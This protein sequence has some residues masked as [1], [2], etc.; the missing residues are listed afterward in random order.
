M[1]SRRY[2]YTPTGNDRRSRDVPQWRYSHSLWLFITLTG[3][4]YN[5]APRPESGWLAQLTDGRTDGRRGAIAWWWSPD[6]Y[7]CCAS[8]DVV[9]EARLT[10][11]VDV[12][13][14]AAVDVL[15]KVRS[16]FRYIK[17]TEKNL[18]QTSPGVFKGWRYTHGWWSEQWLT[19]TLIL[20]LTRTRRSR[21]RTNLTYMWWR[22]ERWMF[23]MLNMLSLDK[24][25]KAFRM[26]QLPDSSFAFWKASRL[27]WGLVFDPHTHRNF[28]GNSRTHGL[29]Q[30]QFGDFLTYTCSR[31][32]GWSNKK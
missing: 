9:W 23:I 2:I 24:N 15:A 3:V 32:T 14:Y 13:V 28:R 16:W 17:I 5:G 6:V 10:I 12:A 29:L 27:L 20:M 18:L 31:F 21:T 19:Q 7:I 26:Q 11:S 1:E 8:V 22:L 30:V 25:S 4:C